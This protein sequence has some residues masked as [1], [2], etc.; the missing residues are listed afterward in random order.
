M[1][2]EWVLNQ[3]NEIVFFLGDTNGAAVTGLGSSFTLQIRKPAGSFVGSAGTK[4][5]VSDGWYYY[6]NTAG[7]AD[8]YGPVAIRVTGAGV[9]T[10][11]LIA[12]VKELSITAVEFTYTLTRSD[13]G[14][15]IEGAQIW[16]CTDTAGQYVVWAGLTDAFGVA[17]DS[18]NNLPRLDPGTYYIFRQKG[19]YTF[20]DPDT[21]V[22]A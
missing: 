17:R 12:T 9:D 4:G 18:L 19:G 15:P 14:N 3:V 6:R 16:I 13:N 22:V 7:E 10:Q 21:E 11:N 2:Y 20:N 1:F 5:E 8:T